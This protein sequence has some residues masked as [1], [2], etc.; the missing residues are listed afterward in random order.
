MS[1]VTSAER[2]APGEIGMQSSHGGDHSRAHDIASTSHSLEASGLSDVQTLPRSPKRVGDRSE[3]SETHTLQEAAAAA[4]TGRSRKSKQRALSG[5]RV[6]ALKHRLKAIQTHGTD[7]V[8]N[9]V[10]EIFKQYDANKN[11]HLC[12]PEFTVAV[13]DG[14]KVPSVMMTDADLQQLFNAVDTDGSGEVSIEELIAFVWGRGGPSTRTDERQPKSV[15][16]KQKKKTDATAPASMLKK[17]LESMS[18]STFGSAGAKIDPAEIFRR[19]DKDGSGALDLGEFRTAVRKGGKIPPATMT[20][21]DLRRL[22][23]AVDTDGS[24]EVSIEELIAFVW[25]GNGVPMSPPGP[26]AHRSRHARKLQ[27]ATLAGA[28]ACEATVRDEDLRRMKNQL[29]L[30]SFSAGTSS[31]FD[32]TKLFARFDSDHSGKLVSDENGH[33]S[34]HGTHAHALVP[35]VSLTYVACLR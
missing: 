11:G 30:N 8:G 13:R 3:G 24:G 15:A 32:P 28:A 4:A 18:M 17:K 20:D 9:T 26:A 34:L 35:Y 21:A 33:V 27:K 10:T 23:N 6:A 7:G 31:G 14:G 1:G 16:Q 2:E 5:K 25:G 22:F 12:L 29:Q 19:Y